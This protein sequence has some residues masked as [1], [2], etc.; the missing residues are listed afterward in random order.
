M[1]F[2]YP[3][4]DVLVNNA[5]KSATYISWMDSQ[6]IIRLEQQRKTKTKLLMSRLGATYQ[7]AIVTLFHD[8]MH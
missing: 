3:H 7:R 2:I 4:I 6:N 5:T 8:M 1:T